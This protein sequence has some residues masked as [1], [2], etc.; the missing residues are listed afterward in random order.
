MYKQ[1][2]LSRGEALIFWAIFTLSHHIFF[3]WCGPGFWTWC[4]W[5]TFT[6]KILQV[7]KF[8]YTRKPA[9]STWRPGCKEESK[10]WLKSWPLAWG[11]QRPLLR[12][13][14][15][16]CA[17]GQSTFTLEARPVSSARLRGGS[18]EWQRVR[19][20]KWEDG[21][22][23]IEEGPL[24]LSQRALSPVIWYLCRA[25]GNQIDLMGQPG[26]GM[27]QVIFLSPS[28]CVFYCPC[29]L[30]WTLKRAGIACSWCKAGKD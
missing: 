9:V 10:Y 1:N 6:L 18:S 8:G 30:M 25:L 17:S 12:T 2:S 29:W 28:T 21:Y 15:T 27:W 13:S 16:G 5:F 26:V 24:C 19:E 23:R 11:S 22:S 20:Q 7:L 3:R 4:I 14:L